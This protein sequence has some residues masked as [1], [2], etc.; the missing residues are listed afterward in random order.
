MKPVEPLKDR[1]MDE[2]AAPY[3]TA[4]WELPPCIA[5]GGECIFTDG[6]CQPCWVA[7]TERG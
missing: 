7:Y 2:T 1:P 5:C 4:T 3:T 6:L